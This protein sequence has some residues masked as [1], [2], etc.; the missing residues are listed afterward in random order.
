MT[1]RDARSPT[2]V[3]FTVPSGVAKERAE[4]DFYRLTC[5][6]NAL[7][8]DGGSRIRPGGTP[9]SRMHTVACRA[10]DFSGD[11]G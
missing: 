11:P 3:F 2:T 7:K 5:A 4:P 9:P 6:N 10:L 8:Q 1:E